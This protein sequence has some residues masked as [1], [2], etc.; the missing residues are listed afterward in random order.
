[1]Q[2]LDIINMSL[3]TTDSRD[4]TKLKSLIINYLIKQQLL[5]LYRINRLL[6][7]LHLFQ[8]LLELC[9]LRLMLTLIFVRCLSLGLI[10][11]QK[12]DIAYQQMKGILL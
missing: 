2:E 11:E 7:T 12:P 10:S 5:R 6:H 8:M 4:H 3:G 9:D 1:M